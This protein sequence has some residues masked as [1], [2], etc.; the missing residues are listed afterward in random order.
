M[1]ASKPIGPTSTNSSQTTMNQSSK[2]MDENKIPAGKIARPTTS[3]TT[4]SSSI[5]AATNTT[6]QAF[7]E[8]T[9]KNKQTT[10]TNA[11][12]ALKPKPLTSTGSSFL[13]QQSASTQ[14]VISKP[15][16]NNVHPTE[17]G[18][19]PSKVFITDAPSVPTGIFAG[20]TLSE[21]PNVPKSAFEFQM[22]SHSTTSSSL[23][24]EEKDPMEVDSHSAMML[25]PKLFLPPSEPVEDIDANEY[26]P[27]FCSD[28]VQYIF[29]YLKKKEVIIIF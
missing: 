13:Q 27:Q 6:R 22:P 3:S 28:Y 20:Q 19:R 18:A 16:A 8:L 14:N 29:S 17:D 9:N 25:S 11:G 26:N 1:F 7:G 4:T 5:T 12:G 15:V 23:L 10:T 24:T 21:I 2:L